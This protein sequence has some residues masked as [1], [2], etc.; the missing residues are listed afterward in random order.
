MA[1]DQRRRDYATSYRNGL[2]MLIACYIGDHAK[3]DLLTR[4][5]WA[6]TRLVQK[7][8]L[9]RV[10]HVEAVLQEHED[11][12]VTIG[13]ASLRDGG[14]RVKTVKLNPDH[15]I[16]IDVPSWDVLRAQQWFAD[17]AGEA[18]DWRGAFVTW[19][20]ATW[21]RKKQWFCNES[22]AASVGV[23]DPDIQ[24]PSQFAS[25]ALSFGRDVT[26]EFF[27]SREH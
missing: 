27:N 21:D 16:I 23:V 2:T 24:G 25:M 13:S 7:G 6:V 5:G 9:Q 1:G 4:I 15:W 12:S 8:S 14:V 19:L 22:V 3:D 26:K 11:G 10:T 18:Y 17:H 20:P